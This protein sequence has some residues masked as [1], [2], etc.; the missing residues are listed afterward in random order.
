MVAPPQGG[1]R[2]PNNNVTI[3]I[4][5]SDVGALIGPGGSKVKD[6]TARSGAEIVIDRDDLIVTIKGNADAQARAKQL[7]SEIVGGDGVVVMKDV[8]EDSISMI[9]LKNW[10]KQ[11][12]KSE[13]VRIVVDRR[14]VAIIAAT[15]EQAE[16]VQE[17]IHKRIQEMCEVTSED[18]VVTHKD[19]RRIQSDSGLNL[20]RD[21]HFL[22]ITVTRTDEGSK[23]ILKGLRGYVLEAKDTIQTLIVGDRDGGR[24]YVPI[25]GGML[26]M[27]P[28]KKLTDFFR[29]V[30]EHIR[31]PF[32]VCVQL[33]VGQTRA[34][35]VG[36]AEDV[37]TAIEK[38]E[39][40]MAA[41]RGVADAKLRNCPF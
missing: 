3:K 41:Y 29:D 34:T 35:V 15:T 11:V 6:L 17:I 39:E 9:T 21:K 31:Q 38:F 14:S 24:G 30:D 33:E 37:N 18:L 13:D 36:I 22:D 26:S 20:L 28:E 19:V 12:E 16:K 32:G 23:V 8:D 7:I 5:K 4:Q 25:Q 27:A 40:V 10:T 1:R 2:S